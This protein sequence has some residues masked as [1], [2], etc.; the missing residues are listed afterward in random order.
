M[1]NGIP[2]EALRCTEDLPDEASRQVNVPPETAPPRRRPGGATPTAL[3]PH[4]AAPAAARLAAV[5]ALRQHDLRSGRWSSAQC[6]KCAARE[7]PLLHDAEDGHDDERRGRKR[8]PECSSHPG[9]PNSARRG[10]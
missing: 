3:P 4:E 9:A 10:P 1:G 6:C 8:D 2:R 7:L 5:E